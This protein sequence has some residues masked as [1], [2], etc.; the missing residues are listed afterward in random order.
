MESGKSQFVPKGMRVTA[1]RLAAFTRNRF[2]I[3]NAGSN[4]AL[5]GQIITVTL[6]SNTLVDLHSLKMHGTFT[7]RGGGVFAQGGTTN[8]ATNGTTLGY[9][10]GTADVAAPPKFSEEVGFDD[11][12][13]NSCSVKPAPP[14]DMHQ[15]VSRMTISANGTAIQQGCVEYNTVHKMKSLLDRPKAQKETVDSSIGF[16]GVRPKPAVGVKTL[17]LADSDKAVAYAARFYGAG[18]TQKLQ[19]PTTSLHAWF[20]KDGTPR[21]GDFGPVTTSDADVSYT[22]SPAVTVKSN[23]GTRAQSNLNKASGLITAGEKLVGLDS[24]DFTLYDWRGFCKE[25]SVRYLP[26]DLVGAMQIQLTL[27]GPEVLSW[28]GRGPNGMLLEGDYRGLHGSST[29]EKDVYTLQDGIKAGSYQINDIYWTVDTISV[30]QAYGD[31]L[32][33]KIAQFGYISL[34]FKEYYTFFKSGMTSNNEQHRFSLAAGSIDKVYTVLRDANY[35]RQM[36][37][38]VNSIHDDGAHYTPMFKF[39]CPTIGH[40]H[41]YGVPYLPADTLHQSGSAGD[42]NT[43]T[44]LES[45]KTANPPRPSWHFARDSDMTF[46]YKVNSVMHP[47]YECH[48]RDAI[49]DCS[50]GQDNVNGPNGGNQ[51]ESRADWFENKAIFP[52]NLNLTDGPLQLMSGYDSR[53]H[54]SFLEF[55]VNGLATENYQY[56]TGSAKDMFKKGVTATTVVETTSELRI[57]AGLSLAVAR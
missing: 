2:R 17:Q 34:L 56:Y 40:S 19:F 52:L 11:S 41:N 32:R 4:E 33:G 13:P 9:E 45:M 21:S 39:V 6:P 55:N 28:H 47:Q 1:E 8:L 42:V 20:N 29:A 49:W 16:S 53:G 57:G 38:S 12:N 7:A 31:M 54:S 48:E 25:S 44:A 22:S 43:A 37:Q 27:A 30:D 35:N 26:T 15:L 10:V 24:R 18:T 23:E 50:Y 46:N 5:P 14:E 36:Q 3:E 51:I